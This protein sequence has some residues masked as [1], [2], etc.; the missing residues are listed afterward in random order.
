MSR[1]DHSDLL[2]RLA[3]RDDAET[4]QQTVGSLRD[5]FDTEDL[6]E[7]PP[8]EVLETTGLLSHVVEHDETIGHVLM[9]EYDDID[10]PYR[11]IE[12]AE[13]IPGIS[14]VLRSSPRSY[15]VYNLSIRDRD[16]QLLDAMRK[17]GDVW[18]CRWAARRGYFVLRI[19]PKIRS[20]SR[21]HYKPAPEPVTVCYSES[22]Y[23]QSQ[24]HLNQ[25][26]NLA[27]KH[28]RES[29]TESLRDA[30]T[31]AETAGTGFKAEHYQTVTDSAKEVLDS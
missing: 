13:Q 5:Q 4:Q 11:P 12:T 20:Q 25:L 7:I 9:T 29:V 16:T 6:D 24:P 15:H 26:C 14:V 27:E 22:D 19:L 3:Q 21:D 10:D 1:A 17:D 28:S 18:Q 2:D 31:Q 30:Q 8:N 23:A